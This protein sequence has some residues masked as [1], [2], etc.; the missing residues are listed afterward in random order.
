MSVG[1][2]WFGNTERFTAI[3]APPQ[4]VDDRAGY[5]DSMG[6][7]VGGQDLV[8][9]YSAAHQ[10]E[11]AYPWTDVADAETA[12]QFIDFRSGEYGAAPFWMPNPIAYDRNLFEQRW[13]SPRLVELDAPN[14]S[15][16]T[17]TWANTAANSYRQPARKG[18]WSVTTAANATPLTD[19][20][21]PYTIIG[22]PPEYTLHLGCTGAAT[23]TAVVRVESWANGA[24][25]AGASASLTL[26]S[27]TGNTRMN[28]T[29]S[30]SSYAYAKVFIT[31]TSSATSTITP[32]SMMAQ[33]HLTGVT[34]T[35]TGSHIRGRGWGGLDF[36]GEVAE[37]T[38]QDASTG[39]HYQ[40]LSVRLHEVQPW[41]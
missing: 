15:V 20:T 3:A 12:E 4:I 35:L 2:L 21:I 7:D 36:A 34:P 17:P 24:T 1:D 31:R 23:G 16:T 9:S 29:V 25:S 8:R 6:F 41:R 39:R 19:E 38:L 30:G 22:I 26:L 37:G 14:I 5:Y 10:L 13:A 33:L 32:I 40:G 27:E 18:T 11:L 28:A